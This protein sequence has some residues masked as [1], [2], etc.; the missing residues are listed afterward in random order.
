MFDVPLT[1]SQPTDVV[2]QACHQLMSETGYVEVPAKLT[3]EMSQRN[4]KY[5]NVKVGNLTEDAN[6]SFDIEL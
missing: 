5:N 2:D 6:Y 4:S 3:K 1:D